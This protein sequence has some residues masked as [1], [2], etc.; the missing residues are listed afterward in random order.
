MPLILA[1]ALRSFIVQ[2]RQNFL[3]V[4][5]QARNYAESCWW[6]G[7]RETSATA[8]PPVADPMREREESDEGDRL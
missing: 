3:A 8:T 6:G 2:L 5:R 4:E 1:A 7:E